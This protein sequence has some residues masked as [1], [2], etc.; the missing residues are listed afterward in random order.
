MSIRDKLGGWT[1]PAIAAVI[2]ALDQ[3]SKAWVLSHLG[4]N[5]YW[6]P[7][8][9]LS[10]FLTIT[11]VTNT[12]AAFGLLR[13]QGSLFIIIAAVVSVAIIVYSRYLPQGQFWVRFSLGLQLGGALG[14]LIDRVRFGH[15]TDFITIGIDDLTWPTFNIADSAIVV[16]VIL[17]AFIVFTEKEETEPE[18]TELHQARGEGSSSS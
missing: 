15:V 16:G 1:I 3:L 7:I 8:P 2:L 6:N 13:D 9:A 10:R 17:L 4:R 14:N 5:E 12:G 11:H 18:A